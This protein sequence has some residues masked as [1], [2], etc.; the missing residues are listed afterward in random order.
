MVPCVRWIKK[1]KEGCHQVNRHNPNLGHN[2]SLGHNRSLGLGLDL[3]LNLSRPVLG[4]NLDLRLHPIPSQDPLLVLV[5]ILILV[6]VLHH[7]ILPRL[8][9]PAIGAVTR[10]PHKEFTWGIFPWESRR[11]FLER[12]LIDAAP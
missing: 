11:I 1:K 3:G 7:L 8:L 6:L 10:L 4:L 5:L 12:S 9:L 2:P